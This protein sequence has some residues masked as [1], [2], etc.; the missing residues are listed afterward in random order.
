[1]KEKGR[2]NRILNNCNQDSRNSHPTIRVED[3]AIVE[4]VDIMKKEYE[5]ERNKKQSFE[6]RIGVIITLLGA[7]CIF[8]FEKVRLKDV[9]TFMSLPLSFVDLLKIVSAMCAYVSFILAMVMAAKTIGIKQHPNFEVKSIDETLLSEQRMVSLCKVIFTYRDI[10][11]QH[12]DLNEK[13][14]RDFK[15]SLYSIL[16]TLISL[17]TYV[18]LM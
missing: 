11:V 16:T 2:K 8:L 3:T 5:I 12:R 1:M 18:T 17:A 9:V 4:Y 15:I 6:S 14:A 13:R 10:I 7:I